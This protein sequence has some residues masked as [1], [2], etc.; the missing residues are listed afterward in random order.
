[1]PDNLYL[2][3][4]RSDAMQQV[5][6]AKVEMRGEHLVFLTAEGKL[7]ALFLFSVVESWSEI[8][9]RPNPP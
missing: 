1:M 3:R 6:A 8:E 7:A 5:W 9:T 4:L 2:V